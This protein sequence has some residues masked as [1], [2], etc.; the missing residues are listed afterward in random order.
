MKKTLYL[1]ALAL[2]FLGSALFYTSLHY[3]G[4]ALVV[5]HL[6]AFGVTWHHLTNVTIILT[7]LALFIISWLKFL[8]SD[9][10]RHKTEITRK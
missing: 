9:E 8:V 3:Q 4:D 5:F 10:V 2:A 6:D 7:L 1:L